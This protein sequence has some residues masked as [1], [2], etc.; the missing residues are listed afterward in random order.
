MAVHTDTPMKYSPDTLD[1]FA[2][3]LLSPETI[4]EITADIETSND[5][6]AKLYVLEKVRE[7][8]KNHEATKRWIEQR[9]AQ[10]LPDVLHDH[11][12]RP[13]VDF[14]S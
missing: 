7:V 6:E 5:D 8:R 14:T 10:L 13:D 4:R 12:H 11:I 3:G 2:L 9:V 1:R